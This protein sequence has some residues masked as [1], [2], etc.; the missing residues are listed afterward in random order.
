MR[1]KE[2]RGERKVMGN[3]RGGRKSEE[4]GVKERERDC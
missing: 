4:E 3:D 1:L 2:R